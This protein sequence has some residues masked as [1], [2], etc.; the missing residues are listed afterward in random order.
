MSMGCVGLWYATSGNR[1]HTDQ[2]ISRRDR[3]GFIAP[4]LSIW[5]SISDQISIHCTVQRNFSSLVR[6]VELKKTRG[7]CK[8]VWVAIKHFLYARSKLVLHRFLTVT[9][10]GPNLL[11]IAFFERT[12]EWHRIFEIPVEVNIWVISTPPVPLKSCQWAQLK[13]NDA[14]IMEMASAKVIYDYTTTRARTK[15]KVNEIRWRII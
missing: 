6:S 2:R 9:V 7:M 4:C 11:N 14:I 1:S 10:K 13:P 15:I 3:I 12:S 5:K 8:R